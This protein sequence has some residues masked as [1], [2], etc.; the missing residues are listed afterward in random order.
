MLQPTHTRRYA[1]ASDYDDHRVYVFIMISSNSLKSP[2]EE[3]ITFA[4]KKTTN[5]KISSVHNVTSYS[6]YMTIK[7]IVRVR[8]HDI[9]TPQQSLMNSKGKNNQTR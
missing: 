5:T 4:P 8:V 2:F 9:D 6:S 3:G 7:Y 1:V